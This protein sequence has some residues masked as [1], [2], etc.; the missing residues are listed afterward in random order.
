MFYLIAVLRIFIYKVHIQIWKVL[1]LV[2]ICISRNECP[3]LKLLSMQ[4]KTLLR[5][6]T[7]A[8]QIAI[9]QAQQI[10]PVLLEI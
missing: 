6:E 10:I 3:Q 4:A 1:P 8:E 5:G 2:H 9:T 7:F